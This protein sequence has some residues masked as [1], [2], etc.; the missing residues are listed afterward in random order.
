[1]NTTE[2][3]GKMFR[4]AKQMRK[5]RK[6]VERTNFIKSDTGEIKICGRWSNTGEIK[7]CGR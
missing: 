1:M 6:D 7:V 3:R 2:G 5:D 4:V